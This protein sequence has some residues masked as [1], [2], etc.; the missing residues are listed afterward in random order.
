MPLI[1][2]E[3]TTTQDLQ[4]SETSAQDGFLS[5]DGQSIFLA[6][7]ILEGRREVPSPA[8]RPP[9]L[10]GSLTLAVTWESSRKHLLLTAPP[11]R[12]PR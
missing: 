12:S 4:P 11:S 9:T 2:Y 1:S 7:S 3:R 6:L 8:L 10:C 5:Q